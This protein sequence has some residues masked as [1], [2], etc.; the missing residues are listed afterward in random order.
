MTDMPEALWLQQ[1]LDALLA[2]V[3]W[4]V[5]ELPGPDHPT[6][7]PYLTHEGFLH[8]LGEVVPF[9]KVSNGEIV[10]DPEAVQRAFARAP[11]R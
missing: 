7:E 10:L 4:K 11:R 8:L 6:G 5:L 3:S 2:Q 9:Y 1:Q